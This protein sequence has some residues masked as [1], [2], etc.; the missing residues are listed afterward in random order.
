M[1]QSFCYRAKDINGNVRVG[2][3]MADNITTAANQLKQQQLYITKIKPERVL[4]S[5]TRKVP[6]RDLAA[7][8]RQLATLLSAGV[9]IISALDGLRFQLI[10]K[11]LQSAISLVSDSI[12]GGQSIATS[13]R[14][15]PNVFPNIVISTVE[16][17]ESGGHLDIILND[18]ADYLDREQEL[19]DKFRTAII[20]P[21]FILLVA[22]MMIIFV[23]VFVL[24][25]YVQMLNQFNLELPLITRLLVNASGLIIQY[26]YLLFLCFGLA[27]YSLKL[28][29]NSRRIKVM[30]DIYLLRL[31][32]I[33]K[34]YNKLLIARFSRALS[35][36]L[37]SGIPL[38]QALSLVKNIVDNE[39]FAKAIDNTQIE[40]RRGETFAGSLGK[41]IVFHQ[42]VI[43]MIAIGEQGGKLEQQ[44]T[45]IALVNERDVNVAIT[46]I[47]PLLE[48]ALLLI[49]SIVVGI[50]L[51]AIMLP[52]FRSLGA[53]VSF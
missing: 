39:L 50:V 51:I 52:I 16:A 31:P 4:F 28:Q 15:L 32:V 25:N 17:G 47:T 14:Q 24:P 10:S 44:L 43:Q 1:K 12:N 27:V 11:Q 38:L 18:L 8:S 22:A 42:A 21:V 23:L 3:I 9:P 46:K 2:T 45:L 6:T 40:L 35:L 34:I 5:V 36:L 48:P 20:Y 33:G 53:A 29:T 7:F 13:M 37:R 19:K 49:T 41:N 30:K 26:W